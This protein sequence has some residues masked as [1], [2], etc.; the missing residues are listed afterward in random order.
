MKF[1]ARLLI[2]KIISIILGVLILVGLIA[3]GLSA[4][5]RKQGGENIVNDW[6]EDSDWYDG[7]QYDCILVLG[8]GLKKDGSPSDMLSDRLQA[9]VALYELGVSDVIV[10]SG[11]CSGEDYDEVSAMEEYCLEAG[12]PE[13]A[14]LLDPKGYSTYESI[15]NTIDAGYESMAIVT[16]EYHLYRALYIADKMDADA[17]GFSADYRTYRGQFFRD[18]REVVASAKDFLQLLFS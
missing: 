8:A 15:V 13:A 1:L 9:A 12:I 3:Y 5:V 14:L 10:L 11:D 4:L 17:D 2:F 18:V 6:R 16:Q 7:E